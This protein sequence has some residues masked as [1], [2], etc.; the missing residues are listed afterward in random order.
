MKQYVERMKAGTT[1]FV[2]RLRFIFLIS[3]ALLALLFALAPYILESATEYLLA[4]Q[5]GEILLGLICT[6]SG[7]F[8]ALKDPAMTM[9]MLGG[10][11][12]LFYIITIG[13]LLFQ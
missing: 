8:I 6:I 13:D 7:I 5:I 12:A 9:K 10:V 1:P 11:F 3:L 4:V 2:I